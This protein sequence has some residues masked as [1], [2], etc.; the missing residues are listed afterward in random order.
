MV[1]LWWLHN[2]FSSMCSKVLGHLL[3]DQF[4]HMYRNK[5][6]IEPMRLLILNYIWLDVVDDKW[7]KQTILYRIICIL[8]NVSVFH[9]TENRL[10]RW[11]KVCFLVS[12]WV[13]HV[14]YCCCIACDWE[15]IEEIHQIF[16]FVYCFF[17][18]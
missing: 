10:M 15:M 6:V 7:D 2:K 13:G 1:Q 3:L 18:L 8:F 5:Q 12:V 16:T 11:T 4:K 17:L 14:M 9:R